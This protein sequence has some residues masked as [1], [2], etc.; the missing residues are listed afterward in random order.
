MQ[1]F[2]IVLTV[3]IFLVNIYL[4][5]YYIKILKYIWYFLLLLNSIKYHYCYCYYL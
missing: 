3:T 4:N 2:V 5:L 1:N